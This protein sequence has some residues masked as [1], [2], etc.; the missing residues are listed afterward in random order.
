VAD[1]IDL[2]DQPGDRLGESVGH[3][4]GVEVGQQFLAPG[5]EGAGQSQQLADLVFGDVGEPAQQPSFG[6]DTVGFAVEQPQLLG[7]D[8]RALP[9][10]V[11]ISA[12]RPASIRFHDFLRVVFVAA[13]QQPPDPKQ[14]VVLVTAMTHR[15]FLHPAADLVQ[16]VEAEPHDME[17]V[18]HPGAFGN[19]VR[20]AVA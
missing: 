2:L 10:A 3:A 6:V 14:R 19:V 4:A 11:E 5:V 12:S 20:S 13:A 1:S 8:P 7:G 16:R 15:L 17:C 9:L 18:Q